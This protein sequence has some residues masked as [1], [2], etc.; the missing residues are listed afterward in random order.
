MSEIRD[1][2]WAD[3]KKKRQGEKL[4]SRMFFNLWYTNTETNLSLYSQDN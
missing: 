1:R 2:R 3:N 4:F